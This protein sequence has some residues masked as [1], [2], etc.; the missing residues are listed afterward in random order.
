MNQ[1]PCAGPGATE[2][3]DAFT[4]SA[5]DFAPVFFSEGGV[6]YKGEFRLANFVDST[7]DVSGF[8]ALTIWTEEGVTSSADVELLI[9]A[10]P[11][12]MSMMLFGTGLAGAALRRRFIG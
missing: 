10:V 1:A 4:F 2:C 6:D 7:L 8:P 3:P 9:Y 11:E 5:V 12:P